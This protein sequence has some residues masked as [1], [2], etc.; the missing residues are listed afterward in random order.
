MKKLGVLGNGISYSLSPEIH[1]S[2]AKEHGIDIVYEIF[3]IPVNPIGFIESFFNQGGV[4]LNITKPYKEIVAEKFSKDLNS[5][6]C[7]YGK[8]INSSSTDGVGLLADLKSKN[9]ETKDKNILIWGMGGAGISVVKEFSQNQTTFIANRSKEKISMIQNS[10][11]NVEE[12]ANQE[13]DLV[14]MC[15][16]DIDHHTETQIRKIN[17]SKDA[18][19]Y[20]INYTGNTLNII[21]TLELVAKNRIFNGLGMLVE[22]AAESYRLWFNYSPSTE[23]IKNFLDERL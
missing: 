8:P 18:Y 13:I 19:I 5:V 12:Y 9:I 1:N 21:K 11:L 4:G 22:Q 23:N 7:L 14:I 10:F 6:N 2:F 3:D 16:E 17:L 20:D 15:V